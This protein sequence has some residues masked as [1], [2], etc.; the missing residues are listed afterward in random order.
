MPQE[1]GP[2]GWSLESYR[3]YL[4]LLARLQLDKRLRG[5][6]D[7]SDI[8]QQTLLQAHQNLDQFRGTTDAERVAWLRK[9]LANNLAEAV[10][11]YLRKQRDI[12]LERSLERAVEESSARLESVLT[13]YS[14]PTEQ[15]LRQERLL[16]LAHALGALPEDQ[17]TAVELHHLQGYSLTEAGAAMERTK[18]SVAGLLFRA[19][20]KLRAQLTDK[21]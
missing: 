19:I 18:E 16:R 5:K 2:Q 21:D 8:V 3:E 1:A 7:P 6:L 10:R 20:K 12:T 15:V 11:R 9:I 14:S 4:R 13:D 17:R